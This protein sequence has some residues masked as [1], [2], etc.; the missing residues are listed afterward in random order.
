L[1]D[2]KN[3]AKISENFRKIVKFKAEEKGGGRNPII[4]HFLVENVTKCVGK[5]TI[6]IYTSC[7]ITHSRIALS[8]SLVHSIPFWNESPTDDSSII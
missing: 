5:K 3:L 2:I 1:C 6:L 7:A 8:V 4:S